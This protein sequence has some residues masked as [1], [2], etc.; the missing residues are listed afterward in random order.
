MW[1]E[2]PYFA[3]GRELIRQIAYAEAVSDGDWAGQAAAIAE[4]TA[5]N[6]AAGEQG[7]NVFFLGENQVA[8][9]ASPWCGR[10]V[11]GFP[12]AGGQ[13][14]EQ[15]YARKIFTIPRYQEH[16]IDNYY[17]VQACMDAAP[18]TIHPRD[19]QIKR[20]RALVDPGR[21]LHSASDAGSSRRLDR[22]IDAMASRNKAPAVADCGDERIPLFAADYDWS[23]QERVRAA[24]LA[25]MKTKTDAMWWRLRGHCRDTRYAFDG[26]LARGG[27]ERLPRAWC[28]DLAY[29]DLSRAYARH[30][31]SVAGGCPRAFLPK[32]S[33]GR[34][35]GAGP[36]GK[37]SLPDAD[38][39][40]PAGAGAMAAG[41][42]DRAR[43]GRPLSRLHDG[44]E[45][46]FHGGGPQGD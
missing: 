15:V 8:Q 34:T 7:S 25:V 36:C 38:R 17:T 10:T 26:L 2:N 9:G 33:S 3:R 20:V 31:P 29:A 19:F 4:E 14:C 42:R 22:L 41:W 6:A 21:L 13:A 27:G 35:S 12:A 40:L 24:I 39:G 30:L 37:A 46:P 18:G 5:D 28:C 44:G 11:G 16:M 32:T 23:E 43:Q 45:G 1:F